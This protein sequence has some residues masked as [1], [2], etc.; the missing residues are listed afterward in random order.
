MPAEPWPRHWL[1]LALT[2]LLLAGPAA[3]QAQRLPPLPPPTAGAPGAAAAASGDTVPADTV[4]TPRE[5][6]LQRLRAMPRSPVQPDTADA[7]PAD[8]DA[9]A[10]ADAADARTGAADP[11]AVTDAVPGAVPGDA[12]AEDARP[13]AEERTPITPAPDPAAP[14]AVAPQ[15]RPGDTP[16][17]PEGG[18]IV[19]RPRTASP[20]TTGLVRDEA[21]VR[22]ALAALEGY[23]ST[24]YRGEAAVFEGTGRRLRLTGDSRV[25]RDGNAIE[26][27]S[28]LVYSGETG[29]VCGYGTPVLSGDIDPVESDRVCYDI[30]RGVGMA[31][32]AR[33]TFVQGGTWYVR[34]PRNRVFL[35]TR[36]ENNEMYGERAQFTSCDLPEPHYVFEA[37][38]LKMVQNDIMVAR[39]VT[40]RFADVP[41]FWLPWMAQSMKPDR[42]SGLL[43]PQFGVNDIVRN[44]TGYNRR[45]S[46]L[47]YYWAVNDYVSALGSFEWFSNNY[48]SLEG[49]LTWRWTRQFLQ[50]RLA[51]RQYWQEPREIGGIGSR[52]MSLSTNSSWRPDERTSI[53]VSGDY[54]TSTAM[55]RD[56]SFDPR[57]LNRRIGSSAS[58]N[59]TFDWGSMTLGAQR[60][61]QITDDRIDWTL[62]SLGLTLRPLTLFSS[63]D[64]TRS[65]TWT[66]RGQTDRRLREVNYDLTPTARGQET[67]SASAS[68]SLSYG[69]LSLSQNLSLQDNTA[70]E[71]PADEDAGV[72]FLAAHNDQT[73]NWGT[74]MAFQQT[75]W[76]GTTVSPS[77][78]IQGRQLRD[79]T[80]TG[81]AFVAAPNRISVGASLGTTVFGFWPG[82]GD[83]E[84]I[85]HK[86]S[87]SLNWSYSPAPTT[88]DLHEQ[89]FGIRD[90]REQNRIGLSFNQTFEAKVRGDAATGQQDGAPGARGTRQT[91]GAQ[92]TATEAAQA[93]DPTGLA[94]G[95]T[96]PEGEAQRVG[97]EQVDAQ[98]G[99][100]AGEPGAGEPRRMPQ[101]RTV[102]LLAINTSTTFE[103]DFVR[104]R[105][106]GRGF[107]TDNIT[108]SIRSDLLPGLQIGMTHSLFEATGEAG[109]DMSLW[110]NCI[111]AGGPAPRRFSP[112]LTR[113]S[114]SFSIDNNFWLVRLLGLSGSIPDEDGE[115]HGDAPDAPAADEYD[116]DQRDPGAG[117]MIPGS[118][119][120]TGM[121]MGMAGP[122]SGWRATLNYSLNRPRP[123]PG[124]SP[125][126]QNRGQQTLNGSLAFRPTEHWS[127][128]WT[129]TYSFT[130]GDF[131]AHVLTLGRDMHRWQANFDFIKS[132]NGNFAMQFRVHLLDNPDIKVDYDQRTDPSDRLRMA[133]PAQ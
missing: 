129:T 115:G 56:Y 26:T 15:P 85:R 73:L 89:V 121:G 39:N 24:E 104:A 87:P 116:L 34:G 111:E 127:V 7:D 21:S 41:V 88:T 103:Y 94:E 6:A 51:V 75:L 80:L 22:Q 45:I 92:G 124:T 28:L 128:N 122:Q 23:V 79:D 35:L 3:L 54:A 118:P 55:V 60:Q 10:L 29:L 8:P 86:I 43:T 38:S 81:G 112:Y 91:Q 49:N 1:G 50:G 125:H 96:Q 12:V 36:E 76:P 113:L 102:N 53:Q 95:Q 42:R 133:Q 52:N 18:V 82:F 117:G 62:P 101:S 77:I 61:Q 74:Q 72:E 47:G 16:D 69:R 11:E 109:C 71:R 2:L 68:H 99:A 59:R 48:K 120:R 14:P 65:L 57:E 4:L 67:V 126:L 132:P 123:T 5:R 84:R 131:D 46:N 97:E 17:A 13:A 78:S 70:G 30:D 107:L 37:R 25:A 63:D 20:D 19:V 9:D 106:E 100:P 40:L 64:G 33:T 90:L 66:G 105:E 27:D 44:N 130:T 119:G 110:G 58:M 98:A 32:R 114:T 31:E 93:G 83:Y 108:N